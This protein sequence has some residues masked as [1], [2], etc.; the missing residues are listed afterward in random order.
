MIHC[1]ALKMTILLLSSATNCV[2]LSL[3]HPTIESQLI[4][5]G[6]R[7]TT[8]PVKIFACWGLGS[9]T[10]LSI[11]DTQFKDGRNGV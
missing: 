6:R 2:R 3:V 8:V 5:L 7:G 11:F 10:D 1:F 4:G 9:C